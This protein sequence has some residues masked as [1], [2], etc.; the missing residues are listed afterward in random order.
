MTRIYEVPEISCD[1][2]K[3]AIEGEVSQVP[4]VSSVEV[5]VATRM[6]RV[7]GSADDAQIRVAIQAAGF[8]LAN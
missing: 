4:G 2:C 3:R 8:E 1:H 7:D 6:V 5:T